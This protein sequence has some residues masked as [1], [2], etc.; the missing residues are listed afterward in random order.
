MTSALGDWKLL[1]TRHPAVVPATTAKTSA[2]ASTTTATKPGTATTATFGLTVA[3]LTALATSAGTAK[4]STSNAAAST[5]TPGITIRTNTPTTD[6]KHAVL[7]TKPVLPQSAPAS[8]GGSYVDVQTDM[9]ATTPRNHPATSV[10]QPAASSSSAFADFDKLPDAVRGELLSKITA[11][12]LSNSRR[13]GQSG[14]R[15]WYSY[16]PS[17][18]GDFAYWATSSISSSLC[19][20]IVTGTTNSTR[21]GN[22]IRLRRIHLKITLALTSAVGAGNLIGLPNGASGAAPNPA[23]YYPTYMVRLIHAP[24][25]PATASAIDA[26]TYASINTGGD[27]PDSTALFSSLWYPNATT[28]NGKWAVDAPFRNPNCPKELGACERV[29]SWKP[30][31][32]MGHIGNKIGPIAPSGSG[33]TTNSPNNIRILR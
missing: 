16:P 11:L 19:G 17:S 30:Y 8:P 2:V 26:I 5:G 1:P 31:H 21:L 22:C 10:L 14:K 3:Q 4:N 12:T 24:L 7:P 33:W 9:D 28:T 15:F 20:R 25:H 6:N 23:V 13:I 18:T 27:G 32:E 29:L